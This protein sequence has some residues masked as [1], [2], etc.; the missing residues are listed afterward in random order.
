MQVAAVQAA[1][2]VVGP[3]NRSG[4]APQEAALAD[5]PWGDPATE[6]L[7]SRADVRRLRASY[8]LPL[9]AAVMA[10]VEQ[11][12]VLAQPSAAGGVA[13]QPEGT[14]EQPAGPAGP[15]VQGGGVPAGGDGGGLLDTPA[16]GSAAMATSSMATA[17]RRDGHGAAAGG[18]EDA[19]GAGTVVVMGAGGQQRVAV[20]VAEVLAVQRVQDVLQW[21]LELT[22]DECGEAVES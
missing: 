8:L 15:G 21:V 13:A 18:A 19:G 7:L 2:S 17:V 6:L 3:A 10:W 16:L 22:G 5:G 4:A 20:A 1:A 9:Q 14:A 11:H 12:G